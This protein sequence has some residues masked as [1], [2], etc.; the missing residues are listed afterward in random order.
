MIAFVRG[1]RMGVLMVW[2]PLLVKIVS[3]LLVNVESRSWII[4]FGLFHLVVQ[5]YEQSAGLL[6]DPVR[7]VVFRGVG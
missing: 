5:V 1:A 2:M 6:V 7:G 3:Y 4:N